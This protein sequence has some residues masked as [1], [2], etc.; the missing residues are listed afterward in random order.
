MFLSPGQGW[1]YRL[2]ICCLIQSLHH[3]QNPYTLQKC[4]RL[5]FLIFFFL[6]VLVIKY[7]TPYTIETISISFIQMGKWR[8]REFR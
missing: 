3:V 7:L 5:G 8:L 1:L 4:Y 2:C 6:I